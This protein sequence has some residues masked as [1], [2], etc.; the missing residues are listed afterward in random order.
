[1]I[2]VILLFSLVANGLAWPHDASRAAPERPD[3]E[4]ITLVLP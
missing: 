2:A 3:K 1:V 4:A